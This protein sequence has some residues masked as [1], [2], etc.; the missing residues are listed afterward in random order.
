MLFLFSLCLCSDSNPPFRLSRGRLS[1]LPRGFG[2]FLTGPGGQPPGFIMP[3]WRGNQDFQPSTKGLFCGECCLCCNQIQDVR[4]QASAAQGEE[5]ASVKWE[6][7][8]AWS[9]HHGRT[10]KSHYQGHCL[11][12]GSFSE[13]GLRSKRSRFPGDAAQA[14]EL[15]RGLPLMSR[16]PFYC[17]LSPLPQP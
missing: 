4:S 15:Q 7:L 2:T 3:P 14:M 5:G 6:S 16:H 13:G 17:L 10:R 11:L 1:S 9:I 12:G 8:V